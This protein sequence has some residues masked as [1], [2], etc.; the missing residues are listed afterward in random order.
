MNAHKVEFQFTA[1]KGKMEIAVAELNLLGNV[2]FDAF[3][4]VSGNDRRLFLG[5]PR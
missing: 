2:L 1:L 5:K 3:L 4:N